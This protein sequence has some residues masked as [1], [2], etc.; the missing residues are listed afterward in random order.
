[1]SIVHYNPVKHGLVTRAV[2]WPYSTFH[3]HVKRGPILPTDWAVDPGEVIG[4]AR[5]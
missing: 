4:D 5:E 2:D 1:M 3:R